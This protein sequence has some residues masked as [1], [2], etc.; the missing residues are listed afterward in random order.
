[1]EEKEKDIRL[2]HTKEKKDSEET[3][4]R[5]NKKRQ[6]NTWFSNT[7]LYSFAYV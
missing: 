3:G 7:L 2:K 1:M 6:L 4:I 5:R